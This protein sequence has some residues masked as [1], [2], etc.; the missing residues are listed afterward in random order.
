MSYFE[1]IVVFG[2]HGQL[3]MAFKDILPASARFVSQQEVSFHNLERLREFAQNVS[4]TVMICPAAYTKVD[5][6]ESEVE[7]CMVINAKGPEVLAQV[8]RE[9]G[10]PLVWYSTDYVF[11]GSG[12]APKDEADLTGPLN[13]Y[14]RSK[15]EGEER[16]MA[17]GGEFLIF[18][19]SWVI[20]STGAN[21]VK[22]MLRLGS[23][24]EELRVVSD[25]W[26][27][28]TSALDL[29]R[30]TVKA[31]SRAQ[32]MYRQSGV[33][34]SGIYHLTSSGETSWFKLALEIF[35]QARALGQVKGTPTVANAGAEC[36]VPLKIKNVLGISSEEYPTPARRPKN[37]R[38]S[39]LKFIQTFGFQMRT[40]QEGL[41]EILESLLGKTGKG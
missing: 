10:I 15:V 20:S 32:E 31:L 12:S 1:N 40:W 38:L 39:N 25:Q 21:F 4:A 24:R 26:G 27:A 37:S 5:L 6:A 17:V 11:D 3:A 36:R 23:E 2:S 33:F 35:S 41:T 18:R 30:A 16:I 8:C 9:R 29:A 7:L 28:P 14:G 13:T 22:T 34:P 19:T